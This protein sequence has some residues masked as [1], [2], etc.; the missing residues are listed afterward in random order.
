[1]RQ[2]QLLFPDDIGLI[3]SSVEL[4][5]SSVHIQA[6]ST[7]QF[8]ACPHCNGNS[9]AIHSRYQ[10]TL[11]DL[12]WQGKQVTVRLLVRKFFCKQSTCKQS[13]FTER[14]PLLM[15]PYARRT[16]RLVQLL[17]KVGINTGGEA[18]SRLA[19]TSGIDLSASSVLRIIRRISI[20]EYAPPSVIGVDDWSYRRGH[21]YG[22][23][24]C[25]LERHR[26]LDLLPERSA[27]T[28]ATWLRK[29]AGIQVIS[30][31]RG[32]EY[33]AGATAGAPQAIQVADRFHLIRNLRD[34]LMRIMDRHRPAIQAAAQQTLAV[35]Q[36]QHTTDLVKLPE[37]PVVI[38]QKPVPQ[39]RGSS[40]KRLNR[41]QR[42]NQVHELHHQGISQREIA[43]QMGI[44]RET[45][46]RYLRCSTFPERATRQV[47]TGIIPFVPYLQNR[48]QEGCRVGKTLYQELQAQGYR[49]SIYSLYRFLT[50]W[51]LALP[52]ETSSDRSRKTESVVPPV[53]INPSSKLVAYWVLRTPTTTS[54][55]EAFLSELSKENEVLKRSIELA[56]Q[57][58][59]LLRHR[60]VTAFS[61][62]LKDVEKADQQAELKNFARGLRKDLAAVG[63]AIALPWSNGQ[64]EGQI[65]RLKLIKRQMY[66][67][68]NFDLLRIRFLA[69]A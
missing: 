34:V 62:W 66:G 40:V 64:L 29:H 10:R 17:E 1:M 55:E 9:T 56:S 12:P 48:W 20:A 46:G 16:R 11:A 44:H 26:P 38:L 41:L 24:L 6:S 49:Q 53:F 25:D 15:A 60:Q 36:E 22:T 3:C 19:E 18:G 21:R 69:A 28:F 35:E 37:K 61:T 14:I 45:V 31:D 65:N 58:A 27:D 8:G 5:D 32:D 59:T 63:A 33:Q 13:V 4:T 57:F 30:R 67:R 47:K 39:P 54:K 68:G 52:D 23:L 51:R 50:P 42:F 2:W 7:S 43:R